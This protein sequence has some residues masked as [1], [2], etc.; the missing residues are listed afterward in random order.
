MSARASVRAAE[1][2]ESFLRLSL[3]PRGAVVLVLSLSLLSAAVLAPK[4][5]T[6]FFP[7]GD[8]NSVTVQINTQLGTSVLA[9]AEV[10]RKI[11]IN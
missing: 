11:G 3:R 6:E 8:E 10:C 5:P 2:S 9:T 1:L 4:I 7:E